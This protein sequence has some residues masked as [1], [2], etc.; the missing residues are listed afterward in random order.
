MPKGNRMHTYRVVKKLVRSLLNNW[1]RTHVSISF[2]TASLVVLT[3]MPP[4]PD[5]CSVLMKKIVLFGKSKS[6]KFQTSYTLRYEITFPCSDFPILG[7]CQS[8]TDPSLVFW[9][10]EIYLRLKDSFLHEIQVEYQIDLKM[11]TQN[12]SFPH[13]F[14]LSG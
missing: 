6:P 8:N 13:R 2:N 7:M 10:N 9:M 4:P 12:V 1:D 11:Q 3:T 5:L 14:S